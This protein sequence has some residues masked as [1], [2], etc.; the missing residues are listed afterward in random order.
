MSLHDSKLLA[1]SHYEA[2]TQWKASTSQNRWWNARGLIM[3][4]PDEKA[5]ASTDALRR[6]CRVM[7]TLWQLSHFGSNVVLFA[8]TTSFSFVSFAHS[9]TWCYAAQRLVGGAGW[10]GPVHP[11]AR[12]PAQRWPMAQGNRQPLVGKGP[13]RAAA[14]AGVQGAGKPPV[15]G[16]W[17]SDQPQR[18]AESSP[19][20]A[21]ERAL[22]A[23]EPEFLS[24]G[25]ELREGFRLFHPPSPRP[26]SPDE[27]NDV[28]KG[29]TNREVKESPRFTRRVSFV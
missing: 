13:E 21:L 8:R 7:T 15:R 11:R 14:G 29:K 24:Q 3:S 9:K 12:P 18:R 28:S 19:V 1:R 17:R 5:K 20:A 6:R 26:E 10:M 16:R 27:Y 22:A 4:T 23:L 2:A 25:Q